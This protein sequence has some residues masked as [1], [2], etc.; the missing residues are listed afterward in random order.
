VIRYN[1]GYPVVLR[2]GRKEKIA[3]GLT[4][5]RQG[6]FGQVMRLFGAADISEEMWEELESA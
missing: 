1:G 3:E 2:F 4:K 6:L 5:T